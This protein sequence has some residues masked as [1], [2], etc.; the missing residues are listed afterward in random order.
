MFFVG[1]DIPWLIRGKTKEKMHQTCIKCCC[2]VIFHVVSNAAPRVL[3]PTVCHQTCWWSFS[4]TKT[5][6]AD[7]SSWTWF[8]SQAII[9]LFIS[10]LLLWY[11]PLQ[12]RDPNHRLVLDLLKGFQKYKTYSL[13]IPHSWWIPISK[14]NK[15][16]QQI[17]EYSWF[18]QENTGWWF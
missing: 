10:G 17:H 2:I 4:Q 1:C 11:L 6:F 5:L 16:S 8:A 7:F 12:G 3:L 14:N 13:W 18:S 9:D 15:S